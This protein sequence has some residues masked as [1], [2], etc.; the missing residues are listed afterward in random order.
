MNKITVS[1]FK[2]DEPFVSAV[3]GKFDLH[4]LH[5]MEDLIREQPEVYLEDAGV[6][7]SWEMVDIEFTINHEEWYDY[8]DSPVA[9]LGVGWKSA[10]SFET[11]EEYSRYAIGEGK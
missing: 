10:V 5:R 6:P 9:L 8:P 11:W 3:D 2:G 1:F 4:S 7:D